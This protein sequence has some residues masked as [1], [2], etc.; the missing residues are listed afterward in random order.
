MEFPHG[1]GRKLLPSLTT[2]ATAIHKLVQ[3]SQSR[4]EKHTTFSLLAEKKIAVAIPGMFL[5]CCGLLCPCFQAKRKE[6]DHAALPKDPNSSELKF[7]FWFSALQSI[8]KLFL[9]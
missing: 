4:E 8:Y 6:T 7:I 3:T 9:I 2:N 5:L 1:S